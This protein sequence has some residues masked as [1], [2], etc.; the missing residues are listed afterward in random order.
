MEKA[1]VDTPGV[2]WAFGVI[3]GEAAQPDASTLSPSTS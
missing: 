3:Q 2:R 1:F